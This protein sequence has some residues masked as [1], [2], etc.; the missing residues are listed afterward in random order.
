MSTSPNQFLVTP[1]DDQTPSSAVFEVPSSEMK[2]NYKFSPTKSTGKIFRRKPLNYIF[3]Y[4]Q[5][6]DILFSFILKIIKHI[7]K[8]NYFNEFIIVNVNVIGI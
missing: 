5:K 8:S 4:F 3:N 7:F 1:T 6:N 2:N